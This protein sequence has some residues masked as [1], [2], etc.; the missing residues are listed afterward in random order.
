[1]K[2]TKEQL[3]GMSNLEINRAL[4]MVMGKYSGI[5]GDWMPNGVKVN[6]ESNIFYSERDYCNNPSD[7]MPLAIKNEL[8]CDFYCGKV[9]HQTPNG[10]DYN[11]I[12]IEYNYDENPLRAIACCLILVL[13]ENNHV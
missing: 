3:Q 11:Y 9:Y 10:D 6:D 7:I 4:A 12:K 5:V 1:M 13:Q 8:V 2:H